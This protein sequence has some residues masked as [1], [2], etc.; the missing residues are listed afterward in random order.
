[1]KDVVGE[2]AGQRR[3]A[4]EKIPDEV[5][6]P[7]GFEEITVDQPNPLSGHQP[8]QQRIEGDLLLHLSFRGEVDNQVVD[9]REGDPPP[10]DQLLPGEK[11]KDPPLR[12]EGEIVMGP[13]G[14][15]P[16]QV[17][18]PVDPEQTPVP[19]DGEETA[20]GGRGHVVPALAAEIIQRP[21]AD[22]LPFPVDQKCGGEVTGGIETVTLPRFL[23][24]EDIRPLLP[25]LPPPADQAQ[26]GERSQFGQGGFLRR[27]TRGEKRQTPKKSQDGGG[28]GQDK[29]RRPSPPPP[30]AEEAGGR[31]DQGGQEGP[32]GQGET[33]QEEK[34]PPGQAGGQETGK[35]DRQQ[36]YNRLLHY[37]PSGK[38]VCRNLSA[39]ARGL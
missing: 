31:Q 6:K 32:G 25:G 26:I 20:A 16:D 36:D 1:M 7:G 18:I 22:D 38:I 17:G 10:G 15:D 9:H 13:P 28:R 4:A 37:P 2:T 8:G 39:E 19:D 5:V 29:N 3:T 12:R 34:E 21:G 24:V 23:P 33:D 27:R 11:E 35:A 14:E 30:P